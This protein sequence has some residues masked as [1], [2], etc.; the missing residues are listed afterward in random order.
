VLR[1][2]DEPGVEPRF[3]PDGDG[4]AAVDGRRVALTGWRTG[5]RSTGAPPGSADRSG[6]VW[7]ATVAPEPSVP[8]PLGLPAAPR[9]PR[10]IP[11][12]IATAS[13]PA[14]SPPAAARAGRPPRR[15]DAR[16]RRLRGFTNMVQAG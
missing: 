7:K 1:A 13:T 11:V 5:G 10:L 8:G 16:P 14:R 4:G 3:T 12:A 2:P 15:L 9:I 6:D